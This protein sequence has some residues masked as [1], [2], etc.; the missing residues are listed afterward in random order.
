MTMSD[1]CIWTPDFLAR[2]TNQEYAKLQN[3]R[4]TDAQASKVGVSKNFDIVI[5]GD[6]VDMTK[7]KTQNLK[8]DLVAAN[9]L[10]QARADEIFSAP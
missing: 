9:I 6:V 4:V 8:L 7:Q 3:V 1:D 5:A 2:F 10:T